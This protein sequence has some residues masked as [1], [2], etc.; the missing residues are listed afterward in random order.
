MSRALVTSTLATALEAVLADLGL[1]IFVENGAEP[2]F[3]EQ[4][5]PWV[6]YGVVV[7]SRQAAS[8]GPRGVKRLRGGLQLA[9][10]QKVGDGTKVS[11]DA[12]DQIDVAMANKTINGAV[13]GNAMPFKPPVF[14]QWS[15]LGVQYIFT[16]DD[17]A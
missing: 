11:N 16:F 9:V 17:I 5:N 12:L 14:G 2:N 6:I 4:S 3:A 8:L 10:F 15:G 1:D 13:M 7:D